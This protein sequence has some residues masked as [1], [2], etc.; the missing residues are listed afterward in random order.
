MKEFP[1]SHAWISADNYPT[2]DIESLI[3]VVDLDDKNVIEVIGHACKTWG[4]FNIVNHNIKKE[5]L[6]EMNRRVEGL[7]ALPM[8]QKLKAEREPDGVSGYGNARN[9]ANAP[10]LTWYEGFCIV[11]SPLEHARKLWPTDYQKFWYHHILI[12]LYR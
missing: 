9:A 7:F 10:K 6:D 8:E 3:P 11:G 2:V 12:N 4:I 5:L 1:E